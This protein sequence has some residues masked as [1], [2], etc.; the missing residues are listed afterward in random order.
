[1]T[2]HQHE[3]EPAIDD[4]AKAMSDQVQLKCPNCGEW[5]T[6]PEVDRDGESDWSLWFCGPCVEADKEGADD[7]PAE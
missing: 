7:G 6:L 5:Q 3:A 2:T 4:K 1:M